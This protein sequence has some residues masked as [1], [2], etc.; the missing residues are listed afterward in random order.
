MESRDRVVVEAISVSS[1]YEVKALFF[2]YQV[3]PFTLGSGVYSASNRN[4]Y[5]KQKKMFRRRKAWPV[6]KADN[7]TAILRADLI[8]S[9]GS[10][11]S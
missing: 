10:S 3:L 2:I 4:E 6:R 9:V 7:L 11:T 1:P 8:D 5:Q